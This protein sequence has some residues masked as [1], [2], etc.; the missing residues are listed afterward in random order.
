MPSIETIRE[1]LMVRLQN[2]EDRQSRVTQELRQPGDSDSEERAQELENEEV[3]E[4]LESHGR[5]EIALIRKAIARID[6]GSYGVCQS[7]GESI[8][9]G[10]L[11][12]LPYTEL[13]IGCAT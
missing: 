1:N 12:V 6:A 5:E 2:L 13:C 4:D 8:A 10:R 11:E 9:A 3:L 7:C